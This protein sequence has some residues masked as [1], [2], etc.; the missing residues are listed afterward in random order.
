MLMIHALLAVPLR[1]YFQPPVI[2]SA[3]PFGRARA[4][5]GHLLVGMDMTILSMVGIP[6]LAGVVVLNRSTTSPFMAARQPRS[7]YLQ[8]E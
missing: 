1:S 7:H 3:I 4:I 6:A 2:M 8:G 5:W